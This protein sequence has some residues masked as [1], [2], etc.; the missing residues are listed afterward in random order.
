MQYKFVTASAAALC[1]CLL[2]SAAPGQ[3]THPAPKAYRTYAMM[4]QGNA[5]AG[6]SLFSDSKTLA[7]TQCHTITGAGGKAG[8]DLFAIGDKYGRDDLIT[9]ILD[10]SATIAVGYSTTVI[11]TRDG[12]LHQGIIKDVSKDFVV[13]MEAE[14]KTERIADG[15]IADQRVTDKSFMPEGL[16]SGLS[17]EQFADLIAYL[18]TL[19]APQSDLALNHGMPLEIPSLKTP[20]T[21]IPFSDPGKLF[22]HPTWF[23]SLPGVKDTYAVTEHFAGKLWL[24]KK[25]PDGEQRTLFLDLGKQPPNIKN[26]L[27]IVFHPQF[28]TN[29]KYYFVRHELRGRQIASHV[30]QAEASA[31][32]LH[33]SGKPPVE[34][35]ELDAFTDVHYGG[36]LQFGPDGY[37]Y[38]GMGD[39][40]PQGDPGGH[41]QNLSLPLGKMLRID[42]EHP[43][44]GKMY[45]IPK[46]NPFI[47]VEGAR[48][49][50]F[51]YGLREPWR[52]TFDPPTGDL[53]VGDV[54]QD[55][56]EEVDIVRRGENMGWNVFEGFQRFSNKYRVEGRTF[57]PPVFAYTR[58]Y[59][60]SVTGGYVY[61]ADKTSSFYGV[62]IFADY[63][64]GR[65]FALTQRDRV[66]D[67][68]RLIGQCPQHAVSIG[69]DDAGNL[70]VVGYEGAIY[71]IDLSN[72][73]FE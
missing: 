72:T 23:G 37:L 36:C 42:V 55:L 70:Y 20:V 48:P 67:Q 45:G 22:S 34:L 38:I 73:K 69:K 66:L 24:L 53:W 25:T 4:H 35:L 60:Q 11:R 5:D 50:I 19:K 54:G 46:D 15:D 32:L 2:S 27:G 58:K 1:S 3:T 9:S 40:G 41:A 52:F 16:A 28:A 65:L 43:D 26:L 59:G 71:R 12:Q 18:T 57:T 17:V 63:Q 61:R 56:F 64:S 44:A 51:A 6:R 29:R 31:D 68:V 13:L 7:C 39:T 33:D 30:Y 49:E 47:G 8:P 62:Y 21:L 14:A 10:P